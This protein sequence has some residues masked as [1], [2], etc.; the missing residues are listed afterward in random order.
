[1]TRKKQSRKSKAG[2]VYLNE[3]TYS[4]GR[5]EI[6]TGQTRRSVYTRVGEHMR[7]QNTGDTSTYCGRGEKVRLIGSIFSSNRFKAERTI[8]KLSATQKRNLARRG[9]RRYNKRYR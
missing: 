4:D 6:Y 8:K 3:I 2:K 7:A 5:K 9:A 1:M